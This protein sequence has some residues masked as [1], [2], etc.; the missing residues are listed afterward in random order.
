MSGGGTIADWSIT[1]HIR[2]LPIAAVIKGEGLAALLSAFSVTDL[3]QGIA[4]RRVEGGLWVRNG[5]A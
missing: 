3:K 1:Q 4:G 2:A 5:I